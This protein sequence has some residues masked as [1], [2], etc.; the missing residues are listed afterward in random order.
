MSDLPRWAKAPKDNRGDV[1]A[2]NRGWCVID[3]R[4]RE[5]VLRGHIGLADKLA[6]IG[7]NA[8][9]PKADKEEALTVVIDVNTGLSTD[10]DDDIADEGDSDAIDEVKVEKVKPSKTKPKS[11]SK[12]KST[13]K[14]KVKLDK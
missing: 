11:K 6:I 4:G 1:Y 14:A 2:T 12:P 3:K 8:Q 7:I 13:A 5:E 10:D 9:S